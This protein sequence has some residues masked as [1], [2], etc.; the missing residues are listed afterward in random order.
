MQWHSRFPL[1]RRS[2]TMRRSSA[3]SGLMKLTDIEV[4]TPRSRSGIGRPAQAAAMI[5]MS[6]HA[7]IAPPWTISPTVVSSGR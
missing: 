4:V 7:L 1:W 3:I 5:P 2:A 6:A